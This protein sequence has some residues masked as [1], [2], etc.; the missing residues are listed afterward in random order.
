[1]Q[2]EYLENK[3]KDKFQSSHN[4]ANISYHFHMLVFLPDHNKYL[5]QFQNKKYYVIFKFSKELAAK[6]KK[7]YKDF[8]IYKNMFLIEI[9]SIKNKRLKL[10]QLNLI[11][12]LEKICHEIKKILK[13]FRDFFLI[14]AALSHPEF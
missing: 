12:D 10:N 4:T 13:I 3:K 8:K 6:L 9:A 14:R 5:F 2:L 7:L 11:L 1:M